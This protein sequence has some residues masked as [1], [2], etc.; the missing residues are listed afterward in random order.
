MHYKS[1]L[2]FLFI[3][4]LFPLA[5]KAGEHANKK[6]MYFEWG[7]NKDWYSRSTISFN[8]ETNESLQYDFIV[9]DLKAV[10]EFRGDKLVTEP[11][12]PQYSFRIG[13]LIDTVKNWGIEFNFDHA[14]YVVE[15]GQTAFAAGFINE[16]VFA[17]DTVIDEPFLLFEHTNGANFAMFNYVKERP[18]HASRNKKI[19]FVQT[20][21]IGVGVVIPKT[22]IL[23]DHQELDNDFHVAG[24]IAGAETGIKTCYGEHVYLNLA[25]KCCYADYQNALGLG[26]GTVS[27]HFWAYEALFTLGYQFAL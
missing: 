10:D 18:F 24:W 23:I 27:H 12:V 25:A 17:G 8:G 26:N 5:M 11:F 7:W 13:I 22:Y 2:T 9:R 20:M 1:R 3:L 19:S 15:K 14:K 6:R 16:S 4:T 21:K